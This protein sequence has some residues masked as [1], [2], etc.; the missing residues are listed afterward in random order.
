MRDYS[1]IDQYL[2]R[3]YQDIY[4]Q[5]QDDGHSSL[6]VESINQFR[7][8]APDAHSVL[9]LGCG[10]GFC[11]DFFTGMYYAGVCLGRDYDVAKSKGRNVMNMDFSFL[12]FFDDKSFDILYSRHSR[13]RLSW[14]SFRP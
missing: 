11:Q 10:E 13:F 3:L 14:L 1:L 7:S 5:P 8:L 9:D 4:P 6:A 2:D 12:S